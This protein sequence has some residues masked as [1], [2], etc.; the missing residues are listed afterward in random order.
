MSQPKWTI[1][2]GVKWFMSDPPISMKIRGKK[3]PTL[4]I[5]ENDVENPRPTFYHEGKEY[6]DIC[7]I[8]LEEAIQFIQ[9]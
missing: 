5:P 8:T 7:E 2:N 6:V 3:R 9:P 1:V 4:W